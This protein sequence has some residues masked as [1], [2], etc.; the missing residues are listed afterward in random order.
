MNGTSA[1]RHAT[2]FIAIVLGVYLLRWGEDFLMPLVLAFLLTDVMIPTVE[3][4]RKKRVP[5]AIAVTTVTCTAGA[6]VVGTILLLSQQVLSLTTE[7]P[8]YREN[9]L[10]KVRAVRQSASGPFSRLAG[11]FEDVSREFSSAPSTQAAETAMSENA[12]PTEPV[13][14]QIVGRQSTGPLAATSYIAPVLVPLGNAGIV[15]ALLFFFLLERDLITH[16]LGWLMRRG[17]ITVSSVTLEQTSRTVGRY[18]RMQLLV[19]LCSGALVATSCWLIG[20]PNALLLGALAGALRYIPYIGPLIG[21]ALPTL[22]AIAVFPDWFH[23]LIIL[24]CLLTVELITNMVLEP[25][26]YGSSTGVSSSGVVVVAFF[27]GWMWGAMGLLMAMPITVWVVLVGR[28]LPG[29]RPLAI[30]LSSESVTSVEGDT[31]R[32][33]PLDPK[34]DGWAE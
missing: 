12:P 15:F 8:N 9:I 14:V 13:Q 4:L 30:A 31:H 29:L 7:L 20:L 23:P 19:N 6:L 26:L 17:K 27:W 21:M 10:N 18:L 2:I 32:D 33:L 11:T 5:N 3:W 24:S 25:L 34:I 1:V 28:H 22:L 16:R